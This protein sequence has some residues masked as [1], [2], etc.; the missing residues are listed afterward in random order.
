ME[1]REQQ[2][3]I[4]EL[5]NENVERMLLENRDFTYVVDDMGK[6]ETFTVQTVFE[7]NK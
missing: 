2:E 3:N 5:E 6:I 1:C 4:E 7:M